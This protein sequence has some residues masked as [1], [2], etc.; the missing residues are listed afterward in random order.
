MHWLHARALTC[1]H[2]HSRALTCTHVHSRVNDTMRS[3]IGSKMRDAFAATNVVN[4]RTHC[5]RTTSSINERIINT[6]VVA[7]SIETGRITDH[8]WRMAMA[9]VEHKGPIG[10]RPSVSLVQSVPYDF[11]SRCSTISWFVIG[12]VNWQVSAVKTPMW[13][14]F[15]Q[16]RRFGFASGE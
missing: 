15:N 12:M 4:A 13:F 6:Q 3:S 14:S 10:R 8:P 9:S 2:V 1:T 11:V 7:A 16:G 5:I